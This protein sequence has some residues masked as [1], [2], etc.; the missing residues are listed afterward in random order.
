ILLA[1]T[2]GTFLLIAFVSAVMAGR[3]DDATLVSGEREQVASLAGEDEPEADPDRKDRQKKSAG[4]ASVPG[5][6]ISAVEI[7]E[8]TDPSG[9][10]GPGASPGSGGDRDRPAIAGS[11]PPVG[12]L[13]PNPGT[14]PQPR[15]DPEPQPQPQPQPEPPP[16]PQ[17]EPEP[18]PEP[19]VVTPPDRPQPPTGPIPRGPNDPAPG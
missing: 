14:P 4:R 2:V 1:A 3:L 7:A 6:E 18:E 13:N 10:N 9:T 15:P 8:T 11:S 17:P 16:E 12:Q 19:P 5:E